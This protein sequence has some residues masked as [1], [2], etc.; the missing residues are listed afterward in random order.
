MKGW[1]LAMMM[2]AAGAA[3]AAGADEVPRIGAHPAMPEV[4]A[5]FDKRFGLAARLVIDRSGAAAEEVTSAV[6]LRFEAD[7]VPVPGGKGGD[8]DL[9]CRLFIVR[10]DGGQT[11]G[12]EGPCYQGPV[13]AVAVGAPFRF[14]PGREDPAGAAGV[15]LVVRDEGSKKERKVLVT[16]GWRPEG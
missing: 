12:R 3:G 11:P 6:Q 1:F 14:R 8:L 15:L 13:A 5:A 4:T 9:T 16:Y 7:L 2:A 10:A